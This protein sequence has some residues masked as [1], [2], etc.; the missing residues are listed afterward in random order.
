MSLFLQI[1]TNIVECD[2]VFSSESDNGD[3]SGDD[4]II[5][6]LVSF[7]ALLLL[8]VIKSSVLEIHIVFIVFLLCCCVVIELVVVWKRQVQLPFISMS[9]AIGFSF[10]TDDGVESRRLQCTASK[11]RR[12]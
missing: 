3:D 8:Y 10:T 12:P 2:C 6:I 4:A 7:C 1:D 11:Q 5:V 9:S